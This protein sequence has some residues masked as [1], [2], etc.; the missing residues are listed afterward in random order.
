[1]TG[2]GRVQSDSRFEFI[3]LATLY[4]WCACNTV[5]PTLFAV[6][7]DI[8]CNDCIPME[9]LAGHQTLFLLRMKGVASETNTTVIALS[10]GHSHLSA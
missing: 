10:P 3:A 4:W 2:F 9:Q 7:C 8:F 6:T 5:S 1:M